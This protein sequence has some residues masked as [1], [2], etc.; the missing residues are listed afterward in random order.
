[1]AKNDSYSSGYANAQKLAKDIG[2]AHGGKPKAPEKLAVGGKLHVR[3]PHARL[4][5]HPKKTVVRGEKGGMKSLMASPLGAMAGPGPGAMPEAASMPMPAQGS[6]MATPP[7]TLGGGGMKK[8]G[9]PRNKT[10]KYAKGGPVKKEG[11]NAGKPTGTLKKGPA[12]GA[13]PLESHGKKRA[14]GVPGDQIN[15]GMDGKEK[16]HGH[17]GKDNIAMAKG[18]GVKSERHVHVHHHHYKAGGGVK[19]YAAGGAG[20][21][22][23]GAMSEDGSISK[24]HIPS[25]KEPI[26]VRSRGKNAIRGG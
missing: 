14:V 4:S 24:P 15:P 13:I 3:L 18:G 11:D 26:K 22:N 2:Y 25:A 10:A 9:H 21:I 5:M 23:H 8:G 1:V 16:L 6:P 20:K 17:T 19:G 7:P 12:V